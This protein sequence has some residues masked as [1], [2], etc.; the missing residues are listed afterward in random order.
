MLGFFRKHQKFFFIFVAIFIGIS[1]TFFGTSGAMNYEEKA[2]DVEVG[3]L[4]DGSVLKEQKLHTLTRLLQNGIEEGGRA[5]NLLNDSMVHRDLMLSGLGEMLAEHHFDKI[6][7]ELEQ[8]W[9]RAKRFSPYAHPYVSSISARNVWGQFA[10]KI[11]ALL[12]ELNAAPEEF[13]KEQLPLL[14]KLYRA[15]ADFPPPLLHQMLFYQQQKGN[16]VRQDPGLPDAN[17]ALFGFQSI[18]DWFGTKFVEEVGQF[19]LNIACI[20]R[21]EGYK[22]TEKEAHIDLY[23]NVYRGLKVYSRGENPTNEDVQERFAQQIR[24][25]GLDEKQA[26]SLWREVMHFRRMFNEV[27]EGVFVDRLALDQFKSFAKPAHQVCRYQL[28]QELRLYNFREMLKFQRYLEIVAQEDLMELPSE[29]RSAEEAMDAYPE[30]VYKTFAVQLASVSKTEAAAR[31]GLKQTWQWET[32]AENFAKL[33]EEFSSLP[34]EVANTEEARLEALDN[35]KESVRFQVDQYARR[36]I[37]DAHPEKIAELLADAERKNETLKVCL[38]AEGN[39]LSGAHFLALLETEDPRLSQYS[40]DGENFYSIQVT[41]KGKGWDFLSFSEA[42]RGEV[43]EELLDTLLLSAY[44][45]LGFKEA[46]EEVRDEVGAKVYKDLLTAIETHAKIEELDQYAVHRFDG[47]L[48]K[49]RALAVEDAE[50]FAAKLQ[51]SIWP[52]IQREEKIALGENTLAVGEFS[53]VANRQFYQLLEEAEM[54]A[55][56]SDIA[57]VK[58][59]LK[60]DAQQELMRKVLKRL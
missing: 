59:H 18:E 23:S 2:P 58:E 56:P 26:V 50:S 42:N 45:D 6:A 39:P 28:P 48:K 14:F 30:L 55:S 37:I 44:T 43:M 3:R 53:P 21:E 57:A 5:V 40:N 15:Q 51:D 29:L 35:L 60:K 38:K 8:R 33:Q 32:D 4:L 20:A 16:Q 9:D 41:E 22:V 46:F 13:S 34:E 54:E 1:F 47:Y 52:F 10:P 25:F 17:V 7:S 11:P 19:I 31:I 12:E 27:G 49:M 24:Y 36:A